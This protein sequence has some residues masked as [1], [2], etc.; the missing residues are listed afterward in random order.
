MTEYC[1]CPAD[2]GLLYVEFP[3]FDHI[4]TFL[5]QQRF[6]RNAHFRTRHGY[7]PYFGGGIAFDARALYLKGVKPLWFLKKKDGNI[8]KAIDE[9]IQ[10]GIYQTR[11]E[12]DR[13]YEAVYIDECEWL[14]PSRLWID[15]KDIEYVWIGSRQPSKKTLEDFN[16]LFPN[17]KLKKTAPRSGLDNPCAR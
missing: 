3:D 16:F 17:I 15:L 13:H 12:A 8:Q 14:G 6:R 10:D 11:R 4:M 7:V 2:D 5:L 9:L 1:F